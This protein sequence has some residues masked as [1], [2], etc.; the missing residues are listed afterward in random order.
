METFEEARFNL[1]NEKLYKDTF[2]GHYY[3]QVGPAIS[4]VVITF[5]FIAFLVWGG[6]EITKGE[7]TKGHFF[8]FFFILLFIMR[9]IIQVSVIANVL[10]IV[11]LAAERISEILQKESQKHLDK[12]KRI[13]QNLND[14]IHFKNIYFRYRDS[15]KQDYVLKNINIKIKKK[16]NYCISRRIGKRQIY[17][18]GLT[19]RIL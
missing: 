6:Y 4:E 18:D 16:S 11:G 10:S 14:S 13:F 2:K 17:Y 7:I 12:G 19:L 9:P 8:A 5:I 3:H 15:D 1:I